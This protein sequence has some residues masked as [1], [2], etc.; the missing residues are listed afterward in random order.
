MPGMKQ[1]VK[2]G[3]SLFLLHHS[4]F[5]DAEWYRAQ[6]GIPA[7]AD[8]AAHY[9]RG[10]WR[11]ADPSPLFNQKKYLEINADVRQAGVCP[12]A[13]WLL[14]G[15][16]QHFPLYA[17]YAENH[18]HV[19]R[20]PRAVLRL[21]GET[22]FF[23]LRRRNRKVRILAVAHIWYPEA[24]DEILEYLKNLRSY[25]WD[26]AATIPEG[27]DGVRE[28]I[29]QAKP[30][31]VVTEVPNR[32]MDILPFLDEIRKRNPEQYDLIVK[33]HSK[34]CDPAKGRLA[35]GMYL[36]K[37][38]WFVSLFRAVLGP[39]RVHRN[40]DRLMRDEGTDLIAA[41]HLIRHDTPR[42]ERLTARF[43]QPLGLGL[44]T[45]Y[46]F[47][48]G[49]VWMMKSAA[50]Q[51]L[52]AVPVNM[53]YSDDPVPGAFTP[54]SALERYLTGG[55]PEEKKHGNSVC[56]LRRMLNRIRFGK[57]LYDG[58]RQERKESRTE[59]P[60]TAVFAVTETGDAAVAG[61]SFTAME[62]AG[63][64]E[65]KG[66][67]TVMLSRKE[68]GD[69]WYRIGPDVDVLVSLLEDYDPQ[70]IDEGAP[71]LVT[72]GWARNWFER[73]ADSPGTRVYDILLASSRTACR[74]LEEKTGQKAELF[75]IAAN[76]ERFRAG[77]EEDSG[78]AYRCDVCF[79]G[80][81]FDRREIEDELIP[82]ELPYDVRIYG[83]GWDCVETLAPYC[84]GHL[85]YSLIPKAYHGAKIA[86]D[87]ATASTKETGSVNSRVFDALAAGCLVLTNNETGA[88]ETFDGKLPVF[89]NREELEALLKQYL[90]NGNTRLEKVKE[91]QRFVLENHTYEIRAE[92]LISLV[93]ARHTEIQ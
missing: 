25:R 53:E 60:P 51:R 10:G 12:L 35:E 55:I 75:P 44:D 11:Q 13:H 70:H 24:A 52:K 38:D 79:T 45:G 37:R 63:A 88:K 42:K 47:V 36:R 14:Y 21:A 80:N 27:A 29:L 16:R 20:V 72:V 5:F 68:L 4:R 32:G 64:L 84:R 69:G 86:L 8:A 34:R 58:E 3:L 26:L 67:K 73:W 71:D 74:M 89:R 7:E 49:G 9:Y 77:Q 81:R 66:W 93:N 6:A 17:G 76:A 85:P 33:V 54:E 39:L 40:I 41:K 83:N 87:D 78:E 48:A 43:L 15:K 18:Y 31:A 23:P 19:Y 59:R 1:R 46:S 30:S 22:A 91:L 61:D 50:A 62:L 92:K 56:T 57:D 2:D 82:A 65:R 90:E 28:K